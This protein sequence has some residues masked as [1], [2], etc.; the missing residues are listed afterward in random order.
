MYQKPNIVLTRE[1]PRECDCF[2][3]VFWE[4]WN[5]CPMHAICNYSKFIYKL[6][7]I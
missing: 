7:N 6:S 2:S 1:K 4:P 5:T 3:G